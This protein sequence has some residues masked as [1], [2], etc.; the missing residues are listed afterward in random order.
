MDEAWKRA[1]WDRFVNGPEPVGYDPRFIPQ[2]TDPSVAEFGILRL[3]PYR[4]RIMP[5]AFIMNGDGRLRTLCT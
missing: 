2:L 1:G 5:G 4:L 3:E